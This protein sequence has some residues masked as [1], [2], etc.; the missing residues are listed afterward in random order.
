MEGAILG[1]YTLCYQPCFKM[2]SIVYGNNNVCFFV[3]FCFVLFC[4]VLFCFVLFCF[5][6]FCF[7]LFCFVL[8][9]WVVNKFSERTSQISVIN[10]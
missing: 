5:V 10:V 6:L 2:P 8:R 1:P 7:V 9:R 3:C 4:F